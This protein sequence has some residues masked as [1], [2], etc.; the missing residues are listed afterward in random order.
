MALNAAS[1]RVRALSLRKKKAVKDRKDIGARSCN[2]SILARN[3]SGPSASM[4]GVGLTNVKAVVCNAADPVRSFEHDFL[5]DTG[6]VFSFA[7][8]EKLASIG[9]APLRRETFRQMYGTL[10]QREVG[11]ALL[12]IADKEE[13]VPIVFGEPDDAAAVGVLALEALALGLDP[14]SG[15]LRPVTL[16]AVSAR[17]PHVSES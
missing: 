6:S 14:T 9:I 12:R 8:R 10:I 2:G 5:I 13:V 15:R 11:R 1:T 7:P 3:H 16:L 4:S 17:T